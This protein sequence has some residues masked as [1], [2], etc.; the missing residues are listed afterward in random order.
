MSLPD[1]QLVLKELAKVSRIEAEHEVLHYLYFA[2][3]GKASK[4]K[5][6]LEKL[7]YKVS[8]NRAADGANWLVLA[9]HRIIPTEE[10]IEK[11][12]ISLEDLAKK[13]S[14]KYDG[15]EA[16]VVS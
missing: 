16:A 5:K 7:G 9:K 1:D 8:S 15:W 2:K 6:A 11:S 13:C 12:R 10:A 4:A 3:E 14:G